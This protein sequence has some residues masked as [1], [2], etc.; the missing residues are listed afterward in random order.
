LDSEIEAPHV[1]TFQADQALL[2]LWRGLPWDGPWSW[3]RYGIVMG[4]MRD[5]WA[6]GLAGGGHEDE[7]QTLEHLTS[8]EIFV[9]ELME[10]GGNWGVLLVMF[11]DLRCFLSQVHN[12]I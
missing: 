2:D 3:D 8:A 7:H 12:S 11:K 6:T 1:A 4:S 5:I 10:T 9:S